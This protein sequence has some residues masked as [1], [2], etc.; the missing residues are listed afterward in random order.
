M[1][2][3]KDQTRP[4]TGEEINRLLNGDNDAVVTEGM[5]DPDARAR[6]GLSAWEPPPD[7][8]RFG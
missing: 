7:V 8:R 2:D 3:K 6:Q 4:G 1:T 5:T